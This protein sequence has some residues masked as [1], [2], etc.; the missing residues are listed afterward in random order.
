MRLGRYSFFH[1]LESVQAEYYY[2]LP[3]LEVFHMLRP[4]QH[5]FPLNLVKYFNYKSDERL[6]KGMASLW[7]HRKCT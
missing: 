4:L 1:H 7:S 6:L 3:F 5:V 2:I